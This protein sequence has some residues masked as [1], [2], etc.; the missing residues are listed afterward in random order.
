MNKLPAGWQIKT[1]KDVCTLQN[2]NGFKPSEWSDAGL[3]IIRIQNLNGSKDFNYFAGKPKPS[4]LISPGEILF[5]WAG[6]K[7]VSFG[8]FIW[9]G[10]QGV[11]NQ[12]IFRTTPS[13]AVDRDWLYYSL[14]HLTFEIESKAHGFK[15][16]LLHVPKGDI[17]R[18]RLLVPPHYEQIQIARILATWDKAIATTERLLANSQKQ[19]Q[20]L[21]QQLLTNGK[22]LPGFSGD[23]RLKFFSELFEIDSK[24]L[25]SKT[26]ENFEFKYIS[27]SDVNSGRISDR[28]ESHKFKTAPSRAR[29][30]IS[31]ED[32][33]LA[34]VRPN[35]KNFAKAKEQHTGLVAS[36][37]FAVL[38]PK[39]GV[40][41]DYAFH[42][43]FSNH[44]T[45]QIE[46]IVAGSNYPAINSS[47]VASLSIY[48]PNYKE[49]VSIARILNNCD[50][51]IAIL[52]RK[53]S[54]LR[55]E[56]KALM[57]QLL[58]G[59]RRVRLDDA[60]EDLAPIRRVG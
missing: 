14:K 48:C 6:T 10:P 32:I 21:L 35:L 34:T 57:Q 33:L 45:E 16:T 51:T 15:A 42:Y 31:A 2:G 24:N 30:L 44:I 26:P 55:I 7:G 12:H 40:C 59:K 52:Q 29:R 47:D 9:T 46:S 3:P 1:V 36:T 38:T 50:A 18:Q 56:K 53:I 25:S 17:E 58:T 19:K 39:H 49:Q 5:A 4:W 22:R 11:L 60:E 54:C 8:P 28:L 37:G 43:L 20:A 13:D 41:S 27:L 23:F